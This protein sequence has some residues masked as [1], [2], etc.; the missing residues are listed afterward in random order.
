MPGDDEFEF[1]GSFDLGDMHSVEQSQLDRMPTRESTDPAAVMRLITKLIVARLKSKKTRKARSCVFL[2]SVNLGEDKAKCGGGRDLHHLLRA[3]N[4]D[5]FGKLHFVAAGA[6][7]ALSLSVDCDDPE[8]LHDWL[9]KRNLLE[10]PMIWARPNDKILLYYPVGFV[11]EGTSWEVALAPRQIVT[12][13]S[14]DRVL[15]IFHEKV[16]L[17]PRSA[18]RLWHDAALHVPCDET[19]KRIQEALSLVLESHFYEGRVERERSLPGSKIDFVIFGRI[20]GALTAG[21]ALEIKVL[22][23]KHYGDPAKAAKHCWPGNNT[24]AINKGIKQ[25]SAARIEL[26]TRLAF[27]A[28]FDMRAIDCPKIMIAAAPFAQEQKVECRRCYMY[29][30]NDNYREA[31]IIPS[32]S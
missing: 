17:L 10:R 20:N 18:P 27:M 29:R 4:Y 6:N 2:H 9:G 30:S 26:G 23:E 1:G 31:T 22:R 15:Q 14:V 32:P 12:K 21:C 24:K 3:T 25:A 13:A 8:E 16:T 19:E 5:P 28:A 7:R 11:D